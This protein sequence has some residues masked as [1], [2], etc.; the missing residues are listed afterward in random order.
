MDMFVNPQHPCTAVRVMVLGRVYVSVCL[1]SH[2][3]LLER[4]MFVLKILSRTQ[5]AMEVKIFVGIFSETVPL[6]R[7]STPSIDVS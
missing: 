6:W 7:S 2:M 4:L 1:L 5:Q 3:S